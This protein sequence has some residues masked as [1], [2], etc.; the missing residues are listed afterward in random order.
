MK[1]VVLGPTLE[2]DPPWQWTSESIVLW[3]ALSVVFGLAAG[4]G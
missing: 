2:D 4:H 1:A 3:A